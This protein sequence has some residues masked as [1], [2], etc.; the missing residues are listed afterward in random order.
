MLIKITVKG[1]GPIGDIK[2][3]GAKDLLEIFNR[4]FNMGITKVSLHEITDDNVKL[5]DKGEE[6][7][8]YHSEH[9]V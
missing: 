1:Q 8:Y 9:E 6:Y 2:A 7:E 5:R 4:Q 3:T